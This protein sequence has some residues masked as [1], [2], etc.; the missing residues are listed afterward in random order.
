[1]YL[2]NDDQHLYCSSDIN[3]NRGIEKNVVLPIRDVNVFFLF[4][5]RS[6]RYENN[7]KK[8]KTFLKTIFF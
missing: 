4:E 3:Y 1:M 2:R 7:D 6:L 8:T 5:K